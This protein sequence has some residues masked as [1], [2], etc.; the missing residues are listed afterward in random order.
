MKRAFYRLS[1]YV[2]CLIA[3]VSGNAHAHNQDQL[4]ILLFGDSIVAGYGLEQE[5]ALTTRLN[6]I[7]QEEGKSVTAING[8][9]SGDTTSGGRSR[10][11]WVLN[12]HQPDIVVVALG[13]NDVLRGVSPNTTRKNLEAILATLK[14]RDI[15]VLLSAVRAPMNMGPAYSIAF[16]RIYPE[17]ADQYDVKLYP[18]L[19]EG[20]YGKNDVMQRDGVHPN[21]KGAEVIAR[22]LATYLIDEWLDD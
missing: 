19:L 18:F 14:E 4:H 8:G 11:E 12:Q 17:L 21:A 1:L 22:N 7:F 20:L 3:Q 16:N 10:L 2:L 15:K 6:A 13:G 9:V 5:E